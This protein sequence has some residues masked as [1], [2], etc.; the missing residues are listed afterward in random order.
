MPREIQIKSILNKSKKR[1]SWFLS[2]YTAN[3]YSSCS[4]NCLYCYIR[5]S[6]YGTNLETSLSVKTNAIEVLDRQL[7]NRARK[8]QYGFIVLSSA[9]DPYLQIEKKY[10][11][12]R[13][14]LKLILK[15]RFPLHILTKSNLIE[16]DFDLLHQI[17]QAAVLPK[18]L[19]RI[20]KGLIVS[21]SFSTCLDEVAEIFEPGA[22]PPSER[23]LA[24]DKSVAEGFRTGISMM[25]FIPYVSD[26][27]DQLH[28][29]FKTM[30]EHRVNYI[31]PATITLFGSGKADSKTLMLNAIRKHYPELGERYERLFANSTELPRYYRN[32][33]YV[34]T[35]ELCREYGL[36]NGIIES[37]GHK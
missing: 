13:E 25:P 23:L 21:F 26:T 2:D 3:L 16:R 32:A 11:L 8:G 35:Q 12:T 20:G 29:M 6:K 22:T 17:Q 33:F 24:V 15:H 28:F 7:A 31:L 19:E 37:V 27:G 34:K 4:F 36:V 9:T 30:K 5:G 10:Q 18:G 14:A 1:D